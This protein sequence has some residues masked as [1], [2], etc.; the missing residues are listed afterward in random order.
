MADAFTPNFN[1][2]LPEVG[3]SFDT[4]GTKLNADMSVVDKHLVPNGAIVMWSGTVANIPND[5][6]L[7]DGTNGTPD[8]RGLFIVGAGGAY[9]PG[10]TGGVDSVTLAT[11]QIPSHTHTATSGSAGGHTHTMGAAG[12]HDHGAATGSAGGHTHT[13]GSNGSHSH[14]GSTNTTGAHTHTEQY[15]PRSGSTSDDS[16]LSSSNS[17]SSL[18]SGPQTLSAGAHSH[19]LNIN[20]NGAHT[21]S[22]STVAD[23]T[24]TISAVSDHTHTLNSVSSHNHSVTVENSGGGGS[25]ENRPP[26]YALAFIMNIG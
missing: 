14:S 17:L 15:Y 12:G 24:H 23:H 22:V 4:W 20:S 26:Y 2:T 9:T 1:L 6:A 5:W 13:T 10:D 18:T 7:C 25:H 16:R 8:L 11:S 3:G 19:S 21:H